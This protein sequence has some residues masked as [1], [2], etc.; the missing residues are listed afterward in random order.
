M[1]NFVFLNRANL[2]TPKVQIMGF[3]V[4]GNARGFKVGTGSLVDLNAM[5]DAEVLEG[6]ISL[7]EKLTDDGTKTGSYVGTWPAALTTPGTYLLRLFYDTGSWTTLS[8]H[9]D[10]RWVDWDGAAVTAA[11]PADWTAGVNLTGVN[12]THVAGEVQTAGDLA[13]LIDDTGQLI[14]NGNVDGYDLTE[15]LRIIAA[16]VIGKVSG[17]GTATEVFVGLDGLTTRATMTVDASGN[18]TAAVYV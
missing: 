6:L 3:D 11:D 18:R 2:P 16:G 8:Q 13:V 9:I 12:V 5:T 14:G 4:S 10:Y 17:A 1:A 7:T 15:A